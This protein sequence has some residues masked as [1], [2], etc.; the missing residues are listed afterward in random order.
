MPHE[1]L[2]QPS[3]ATFLSPALQPVVQAL[4]SQLQ[5]VPLQTHSVQPSAA[6]F[7]CIGMSHLPPSTGSMAPT[8]ES[9]QPNKSAPANPESN[10]EPTKCRISLCSFSESRA[11]RSTRCK[12][13][14]ALG[15]SRKILGSAG[16]P[17]ANPVVGQRVLRVLRRVLLFSALVASPVFAEPVPG[18]EVRVERSDT[19]ADCPSEQALVQ[20][21]LALGSAPDGVAKGSTIAVR[22]E[23]DGSSYRA[24][25][26]ASGQKTGERELSVDDPDCRR[27]ADAVAVVV[28]VLLDIVPQEAAASFEVPPPSGPPPAPSPRAKSAPLPPVTAP[29]ARPHVEKAPWALALRAEASLSVGLLGGAVSPTFGGS[30]AVT[31]GPWQAALGGFWVVPREVPFDAVPARDAGVFVT[32][33]LGT[34]DGCYRFAGGAQRSWETWVC[35]RFVAG[36]ISGDGR[37]FDHNY[38]THEAWFGAG[39]V[40]ALRL[41]LSRAFALRFGASAVVTLGDH[42]FRVENYGTAF[43]SPPLSAMVSFGPELTIW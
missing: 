39:P 26:S 23:R 29:A 12:G 11:K 28:A 5:V 37:G 10:D 32:L 30:A 17:F 40:F 34:A 7:D 14:G 33:A 42:T 36:V 1:Q 18:G 43:D 19:A 13:R 6:V 3:S 38:P 15:P 4:P 25:V 35:A 16:R 2:L 20:A 22:F 41:P 24:L 8:V 27:L 9:E 31:H 21:A